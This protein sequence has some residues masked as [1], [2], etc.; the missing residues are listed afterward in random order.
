MCGLRIYARIVYFYMADCGRNP[1]NKAGGMEMSEQRQYSFCPKCGAVMQNNVCPG[2]GPKRGI[3]RS[4]VEQKMLQADRSYQEQKVQHAGQMARFGLLFMGCSGILV[5]VWLIYNVVAGVVSRNLEQRFEPEE[6]EQWSEAPAEPDM[7]D[8]IFNGSLITEDVTM[9]GEPLHG[10]GSLYGGRPA[11][12]M[13]YFDTYEPKPT[14]DFYRC[15]TDA[16]DYS[17]SYEVNWQSYEVASESYTIPQVEMDNHELE[18]SINFAIQEMLVSEGSEEYWP[19]SVFYVTYMSED[20]LSIVLELRVTYP[21]GTETAGLYHRVLRTLNFNMETG[22]E[23]PFE[24]IISIRS[25]GL[26]ARFWD[27]CAYEHPNDEVLDTFDS[28]ENLGEKLT[29]EELRIAF[30]TPV[31][32]ELGFNHDDGYI[33][34]TFQR[35][36]SLPFY[37]YFLEAPSYEP[38]PDYTPKSK[39]HYYRRLVNAIPEECEEKIEF[40]TR[41]CEDETGRYYYY[42]PQLTDD[43]Q[44]NRELINER[45]LEI[46]CPL[47]EE[48]YIGASDG[49]ETVSYV[50]YMDE[51]V[52]SVV[53]CTYVYYFNQDGISEWLAEINSVTFDLISGREI[54]KEEILD[55]DIDFAEQF[56][57]LL[58]EQ[59][60]K[61]P[62]AFYL[63]DF[64]TPEGL[65]KKHLA[66]AQ[67]SFVFY[68]PVG[69]EV[70]VERFE[71]YST[72]TVKGE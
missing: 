14:D 48:A 49:V 2:C 56:L 61:N 18:T 17:L 10:N 67:S 22:E 44:P 54:P 8:E 24:E 12:P 21:E 53:V 6:Q 40:V 65:L 19:G 45:I 68:T 46:A 1:R 5:V 59:E 41:C 57:E 31:G 20:I 39:D 34:A 60:E 33:T 63:L 50:T 27:L 35:E 15:L 62:N 58:E 26:C 64:E 51:S 23:I 38:E 71:K 70:G 42:Y 13:V 36:Q 32:V 37:R 72:V 47:R 69:I 55:P 9:H 52:M 11:L 7:T 28:V 16:I 43:V 66:N 3:R 25:L 4:P 30:Y 29:D